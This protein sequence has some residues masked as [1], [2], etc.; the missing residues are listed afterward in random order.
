MSRQFRVIG[1]LLLSKRRRKAPGSSE[2][3]S[4][5]WQSPGSLTR[6]SLRVAAMAAV[7]IPVFFLLFDLAGAAC[8]GLAR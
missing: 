1:P 4:D 5:P 2:C 3:A 6:A 7:Y 8:L